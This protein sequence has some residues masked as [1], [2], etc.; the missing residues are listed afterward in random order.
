MILGINTCTQKIELS[1]LAD[2]NIYYKFSSH[3]KMTP[4]LY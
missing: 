1:V 3:Q 4:N 2:N